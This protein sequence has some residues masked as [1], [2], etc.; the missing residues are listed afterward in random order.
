MSDPKV[1]DTHEI[2]WVRNIGGL[3]AGST[4][5]GRRYAPAEFSRTAC[6]SPT[7]AFLIHPEAVLVGQGSRRSAPLAGQRWHRY[8][9]I[10]HITDQRLLIAD[11]RLSRQRCDTAGASPYQY[12]F[13]LGPAGS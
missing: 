9:M 11:G 3:S 7:S 12:R 10:T 4:S 6:H 2:S 5:F 1:K 13:A 8:S